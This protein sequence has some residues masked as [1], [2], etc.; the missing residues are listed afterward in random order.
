[1]AIVQ[2]PAAV[3]QV[4]LN[5]VPTPALVCTD[6]GQSQG[7]RSLDYATLVL[8]PHPTMPPGSNVKETRLLDDLQQKQ[9]TIKIRGEDGEL[10]VVHWGYI[11]TKSVTIDSSEY[12]VITSRLQPYH[13][14]NPIRG[15]LVWSPFAAA[16]VDSLEPIVFNPQLDGRIAQNRS[17]KTDGTVWL[18]IHPEC[19]RT[20]SAIATSGATSVRY[21]SLAH[22]VYYLCWTGNR[23]ETFID[24]PNIMDLAAVLPDDEM[25]LRNQQQPFGEYL[26]ANLDALLEPYGYGWKIDLS[27][28]RPKIAVFRKNAGDPVWA[29]L[30]NAGEWV[31]LAKSN[32]E[33]IN[34]TTDV[35]NR[36]ANTMEVYGDN[37]MVEITTEL[38]PGWLPAYDTILSTTPSK[39]E[40]NGGEAKAWD[41][42]P[43]LARVWRDWV[44]N[45]AGDYNGLRSRPGYSG[46][47]DF[48]AATGL[49]VCLQ[50][51]RRRLLPC[52]TIGADLRPVGEHHGVVV[53]YFRWDMDPTSTTALLDTGTWLPVEEATDAASCSVQVL[54]KECGIR[55]S[56]HHIPR[57]I[58]RYGADGQHPA[59][60]RVT[61]TVEMDSRLFTAR[62]PDASANIHH[63]SRVLDLGSKFKRRIVRSK[64]EGDGIHANTAVDDVG[65]ADAL[66]IDLL[67]NWNQASI[68]GTITL[69][70]V[71]LEIAND[72]IGRP[73]AGI[74]GRGID[75]QTTQIDPKKYPTITAVK[76]DLVSHKTILSLD[77]WKR[78]NV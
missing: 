5:A 44:L 36:L 26:P 23:D 78:E 9:C 2:K 72:C 58:A 53:E 20:P 76:L 16:A 10:R 13:F 60:I 54:D 48:N 33:S 45:E 12:Q 46:P 66:G 75:F 8:A 7:G 69:P 49:P 15:M 29:Q 51:K 24:N 31:D 30:Q 34:V 22:A 21:W 77:T 27:T 41:T 62:L 61:A 25:M 39:T 68:S 4:F 73:F 17:D 3:G 19:Q 55:F 64:F 57:D 56:G 52:I 59:R 50:P 70:G 32:A 47:F 65:R 71:D 43:N 6:V 42:D 38:I 67:A 1:M 35:A 11:D 14:G 40:L 63:V 28:G 37:I 18:F 74:S